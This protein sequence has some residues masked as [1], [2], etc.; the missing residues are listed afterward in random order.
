MVLLTVVMLKL[1]EIM[2]DMLN[3]YKDKKLH[4]KCKQCRQ[5]KEM[6]EYDFHMEQS[7]DTCFYFHYNEKNVYH[8]LNLILKMLTTG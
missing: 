5:F 1:M 7:C 2:N 4:K 6:N 3:G 8:V